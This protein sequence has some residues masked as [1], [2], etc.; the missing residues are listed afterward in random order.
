MENLPVSEPNKDKVLDHDY[1]G[2]REYDNRLPN[3][4]LMILYGTVVFAFCYWVYY[5]TWGVGKT[6]EQRYQVTM[7]EA[8]QAE[9]FKADGQD[10]TNDAMWAMSRDPE[11]TAEGKAIF[12]QFC[13]VCHSE[14]GR[15]NVGPNLTDSYWLHGGKPLDI[16]KTVTRGVPDKGMAAWGNQLGPHR[17]QSVVSYVLTLHNLN[18]P[19]KAPQ[20]EPEADD[21]PGETQ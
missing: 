4:W 16:L 15:G 9:F 5:H 20:G 18:L 7:A 3:W 6:P 1:D 2:I 17:V 10:L 14:E 13:V 12:Q 19:G 11:R 21:A 8:A